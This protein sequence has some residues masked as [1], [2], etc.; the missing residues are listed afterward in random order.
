MKWLKIP[1]EN[2]DDAAQDLSVATPILSGIQKVFL[3]EN[4]N[5]V[6]IVRVI[7]QD[8]IDFKQFQFMA[9]ISKIQRLDLDHVR[10]H[11]SVV[12]CRR[13]FSFT[14]GLQ[15]VHGIQPCTSC[16]RYVEHFL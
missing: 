14:Y 16:K 13:A 1:N 9:E 15:E 3:T 12:V 2:A 4:N 7:T 10:Q 6:L 8:G 5:E 11:R